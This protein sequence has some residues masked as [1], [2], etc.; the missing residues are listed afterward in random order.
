MLERR[1][2]RGKLTVVDAT[3]VRAE[4]RKRLKKARQYRTWRWRSCSTAGEDLP[5]AQFSRSD[6]AFDPTLFT[7]RSTTSARPPG[8]EREGFRYVHILN[9]AEDVEIRRTPLWNNKK[10]QRGPFDILGDVHGCADE[11][12]SLLERLGWERYQLERPESPWGGECWRHPA[13]RKAV[14]VG[15]LVDR[16]PRVLDAVRI[17]RNMVTAGAAFCVAGNHDVKTHGAGC[18]AG[19]E[20]YHRAWTRTVHR[21]GRVPDGGGSREAGV[22]PGRISQPF[23]MFFREWSLLSGLMPDSGRC[24]GAV[25]GLF[26]SFAFLEKPRAR[27]MSLDCQYAITGPRSIGERRRL[28]MATLLYR[29]SSG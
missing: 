15:D 19:Q 9:D 8:L 29:A 21:G 1:L 10:D 24:T 7:A 16:G 11:L 17:V 22:L 2:A 28:S 18:A 4:D 26:G 27:Q 25:R 23:L 12:R 5:G 6:R 3:N 20:G 13:G 14:F